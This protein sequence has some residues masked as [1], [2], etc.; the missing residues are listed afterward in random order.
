METQDSAPYEQALPASQYPTLSMILMT[1]TVYPLLVMWTLLSIVCFPAAFALL[2]GCTLWSN[3]KVMRLCVWLYGKGW[4]A[5]VSPFV[6]FKRIFPEKNVFDTPSIIVVNHLSFFDTY[7][8]AMLPC[9]DITFAVRSWPFKM[10]WYA[11]FMR[12]AGYMDVE[13]MSFDECLTHAR[14]VIAHGGHVLFFPEGHR[15]RTGELQRFYSG[16]F[17]LAKAVD[18][19]IIPLCLTG[20][21]TLL[22]PKRHWLAPSTVRMA[23][24]P[25]LHPEDFAN[26]RD[27]KRAA[28]SAMQ[29]MIMEMRLGESYV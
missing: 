5:V 2:K 16:A 29:E 11:F 14:T 22:P 17:Q 25:P 4:M 15:S 19:P 18:C 6:S 24:L 23:T 12:L 26:H 3:A 27:M 10:P 21:D 20:T 13:R 8:M 9:S 7:C 28:K 1:C